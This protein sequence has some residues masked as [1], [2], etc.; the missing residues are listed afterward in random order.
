LLSG[1][2]RKV[3]ARMKSGIE[4][5]NPTRGKIKKPMNARPRA[6]GKRKRPM[7]RLDIFSVSQ[8]SLFI[9]SSRK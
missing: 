1:A 5:N 6:S 3:T 2:A 4:K 9:T 8:S 7:V